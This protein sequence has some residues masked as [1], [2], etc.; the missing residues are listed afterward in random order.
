M[1]VPGP[2]DVAR[3]NIELKARCASLDDVR[4]HCIRMGAK[5]Q[6]TLVQIDTYFHATHGRLKLREI[7]G[8][9]AELIAYDRP[10]EVGFR[11]SEYLVAPVLDPVT[12]KAALACALGLRGVVRKRRDLFLWHNVRI[13][14]D[15]VE[16]LGTFVEFEAVLSANDDDPA[17]RDRLHKLQSELRITPE[18]RVAGSYSDL[19]GF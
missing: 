18:D 13:H 12:I 8:E 6:G 16:N 19:L 4:S 14:L 15:D 10:N 5:A 9:T 3:K 1:H 17:S 11:T 7:N 2:T